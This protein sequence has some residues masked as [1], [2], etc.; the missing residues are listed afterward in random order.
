MKRCIAIFGPTA[1]GKSSLALQL[2]KRYDG[3]IISA[4]SMHIY[5][6]MNIG[7][8]KPTAEEMREVPHKLID[9]CD[10]N[11]P[12]SVWNYKCCAEEAIE[13]ALSQNKLPI[14]VGGTGL[15]FDSL[16][17]NTDFGDFEILPE[18]RE[19]LQKRSA[20]GENKI[21]LEELRSIDPECAAPL[22]ENDSKR[23]IRGLEVYLSTGRTLTDFKQK[24]HENAS[25]F[26]FCKFNLVYQNRQNLYHRINL[27]VDQMIQDGLIDETKNLLQCHCFDSGTA[28]QAIGYKEI[29]PYLLNQRDLESCID[30]LKQKTR[31]Y[32]K[33]QITWFRRYS[34]AHQICMDENPTPLETVNSITNT[35]LKEKLL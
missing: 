30:L 28:K 29:L 24:S 33:R 1:S 22:H 25:K 32:A 12:F 18:I 34:D 15:Y 6:N 23:I 31:N 17:N 8:A 3:V 19:N 26:T 21:L 11:E 4:D 35:F 5:R 2:A 9:I 27:R 14:I 16:F 13:T 7:T 20:L 10:A